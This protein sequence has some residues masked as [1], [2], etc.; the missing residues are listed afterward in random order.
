MRIVLEAVGYVGTALVVLSMMM[1]SVLRLRIVT[2][3]RSPS[4]TRRPS[5]HTPSCF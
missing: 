3:A 1:T 2:E 5:E 4:F